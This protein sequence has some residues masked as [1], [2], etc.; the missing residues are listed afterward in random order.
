MQV[1]FLCGT[2]NIDCDWSPLKNI[3]S[4]F[5]MIVSTSHRK[6]FRKVRFCLFWLVRDPSI[7]CKRSRM[8]IAFSISSTALVNVV[9]SLNSHRRCYSC[10]KS[11]RCRPDCSFL[12]RSPRNARCA[13][14][15]LSVPKQHPLWEICAAALQ[16]SG[17]RKKKK[18]ERLVL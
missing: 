2:N 7:P 5:P 12:L 1:P 16:F 17:V 15:L 14:R 3:L 6:V 11:I 9:D 13:V 18:S 4:F 8:H 10:G